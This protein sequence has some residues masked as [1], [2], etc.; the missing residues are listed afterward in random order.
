MRQSGVL[1]TKV[2]ESQG[3]S[4]LYSY[5]ASHSMGDVGLSLCAKITE[6]M[7]RG[8]GLINVRL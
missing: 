5:Q 7:E 8:G 2:S 1:P 3:G 4:T 6:E